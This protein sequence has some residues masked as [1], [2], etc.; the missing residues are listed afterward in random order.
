VDLLTVKQIVEQYPIFTETSLRWLLLNRSTTGLTDAT[1]KIGRR[2][3]IDRV[4]FDK[5]LN[6]QRE[7]KENNYGKESEK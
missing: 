7:T 1:V 5:W 2:V 6:S 4:E 3:F